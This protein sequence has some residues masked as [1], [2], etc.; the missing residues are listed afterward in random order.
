[1]KISIITFTYNRKIKLQKTIESVLKQTYKNWEYFIVDDGS[2]D[3]TKDLFQKKKYN[4]INYTYLANNTGKGGAF[5]KS[6]IINK[7][8]GDVIIILDSDDCLIEGAFEKIIYDFQ[9]SNENVWCIAYDWYPDNKKIELPKM[10]FN[11][12]FEDFYSFQIFNDDYPLNVNNNG[13]RDYLFVSK[14]EYWRERIKYFTK[15]KHLYTSEY[16]VAMNNV[17]L[18]KFTSLKLYF[19]GFDDDCVTKGMNFD[20]YSPITNFT[21]EYLFLKYQNKMS[22]QY[23]DYTIKSLILNYFIY[24]GNRKKIFSLFKKEIKNLILKIKN[25]FLFSLLFLIPSRFIIILKK[26]LKHKRIQR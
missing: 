1:M 23:Y 17:Y 14:K 6:N 8:T 20:K 11:N 10:N 22:K 9:N 25:I 3:N 24:K 21:R 4:K 15:G 13:Y 7:V 12:E 2:N 26:F 16:D 19:M 18:V 5:I